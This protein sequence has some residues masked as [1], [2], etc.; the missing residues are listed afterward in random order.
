MRWSDEPP[1]ATTPS[2]L[3]VA[4]LDRLGE[5]LAER[6]ISEHAMASAPAKGP[7]PTTLIQM[8]AQI[9]TSTERMT[10]SPRRTAKRAKGFGTTLRAAR[11]AIGNAIRAAVSVPRK[12]MPNVSARAWR[13]RV[14]RPPALGGSISSAKPASRPSPP[15]IRAS[16]KSSAHIP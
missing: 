7:S 2:G 16:E 13:N 5:Q 10:S 9:S 1:E 12:A 3:A 14:N 15:K 4:G 8:S 6:T 11:K